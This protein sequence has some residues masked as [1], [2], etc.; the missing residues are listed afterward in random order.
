MKKTINILEAF[1][2]ILGVKLSHL[3]DMVKGNGAYTGPFSL[4]NVSRWFVGGSLRSLERFYAKG[5]EWSLYRF[6]LI[7]GLVS[8]HLKDLGSGWV[9]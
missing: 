9:L 3:S 4:T 1:Q 8:R 2:K 5:Q 6:E 7:L